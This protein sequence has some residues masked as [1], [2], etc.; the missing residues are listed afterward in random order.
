MKKAQIVN[1]SEEENGPL[2]FG[3]KAVGTSFNPSRDEAVDEA[4]AIIAL[5]IDQMKDLVHKATSPGQARHASVAI[6][7]LEDAQMRMVKA[8]TWTE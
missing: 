8:I 2:T 4:K 1:V 6:T 7:M 3:Q 5:A